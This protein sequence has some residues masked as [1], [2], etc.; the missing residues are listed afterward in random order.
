VVTI[1]FHAYA[2]ATCEVFGN[3]ITQA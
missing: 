1:E 2:D 3:V